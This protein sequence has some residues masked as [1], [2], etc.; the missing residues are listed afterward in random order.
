MH[1]ATEMLLYMTTLEARGTCQ[2]KDN[3]LS[4]QQ[5]RQWAAQ[6]SNQSSRANT[7]PTK[8]NHIPLAKLWS[9]SPSQNE[10]KLLEHCNCMSTGI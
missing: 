8:N 6:R 5:E 3:R 1:L 2:P 10:E 4:T 7:K 9:L